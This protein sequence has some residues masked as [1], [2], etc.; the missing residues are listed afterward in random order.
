MGRNL[1]NLFISESFQYLIQVSGS[2]LQTGLGSTLTGS[3]LITSSKADTATSASF[4]TTASY[5]ASVVSASYA[6]SSSFSNTSTSA[7]YAATATSSSYAI[8]STNAVSASVATSASFATTASYALNVTPTNT[9]SLLVTASAV[10]NVITFTKGDGSTFPVTVST[11]SAVSSSYATTASLALNNVLTASNTNA[12]I[13]YTKGDGTTFT[14]VINNVV[15]ATSASVA[16]S[17]SYAV[18]ASQ[19]QNAIS[20]SYAISASQATNA[21]TA[22][23]AETIA[24]GLSPTF[25]NVTA[26]NVLITGTASVALLYTQ[27]VSSSVIYSSG[28]NQ[29]GDASN[30]VQTL[31]GTFNVVNG[32]TNF[33][34]SVNSVNG[35]TGSLAGTASFATSASQAVSSSFATSASYAVSA[36]QAQNAVSA[37]YAPL[38]T[39]LPGFGFQA[40]N[41][42]SNTTNPNFLFSDTGSTGLPLTL[43]TT[44]NAVPFWEVGFSTGSIVASN[45]LTLYNGPAMQLRG[46]LIF[47]G[48]NNTWGNRSGLSFSVNQQEGASF[49]G[50]SNNNIKPG[51]SF[52]GGVQIGGYGVALNNNNNSAVDGQVIVGGYFPS[53]G[54]G[55]CLVALGMNGGSVGDYCQNSIING[56]GNSLSDYCSFA[57]NIAGAN[58]AVRSGYAGIIGG[59]YND[60]DGAYNNYIYGGQENNIG[61]ATYNNNTIVG[62]QNNNIQVITDTNNPVGR[63]EPGT[64][65][66]GGRFNTISGSVHF[67]QIIGGNNNLMRHSGSVILGGANITS[68]AHN[69]VY[70]PNLIF[71]G[72]I[73]REGSTTST[74][75]AMIIGSGSGRPLSVYNGG[76]INPTFDATESNTAM[77][78]FIAG[79][80]QC[81]TSMGLNNAWYFGYNYGGT[82]TV[83]MNA[84]NF[85][86]INYGLRISGSVRS[87]VKS[88]SISSNTASLDLS[89]GNFFTVQLASGSNTYIN[90]TNILAGQTINIKI[91]T[92]GSGTVSFPTSVLQPSGSTYTPTTTT[93]TDVITL[94]AFD[95]TNLY[96]S[97]I[98]NFV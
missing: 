42:G 26:S 1:T 63:F 11:G 65:I 40:V 30:D 85:T 86:E 84:N 9:G 13:T 68:S 56:S 87:E 75:P 90:P 78:H 94:I 14:N 50:G 38:P 16:T 35:Y 55:S 83:A 72:S 17:S 24:S 3:L 96:L 25:A 32:P 49:I 59:Y 41:S 48:H 69:T 67:S 8:N 46:T 82:P 81:Y 88:L 19:A 47:G 2:E 92:T 64:S 23:F 31:Y 10:S 60:V 52:R 95:S 33:T 77:N 89:T 12:T 20:S 93:G 27:T 53:I 39:G 18:S 36:S 6:V 70:V 76:G 51:N 91:N 98:K 97:N 74:S 29:F 58:N 73:I 61:S 34:G 44:W 54:G 4:A 7:S 79:G 22:S 45:N 28:S 80:T 37:S 62:G 66:L 71:T 15:N 57:A 5:V 43:N 21:T